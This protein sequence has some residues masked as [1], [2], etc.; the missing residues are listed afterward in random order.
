MLT[1]LDAKEANAFV[2]VVSMATD[3]TP[4]LVSSKLTFFNVNARLDYV[5]LQI[6][7]ILVRCF[8]FMLESCF[9][10]ASG[11]PHYKT[12]DGEMIH[13][14]GTCKYTLTRSTTSNDTCGFH[15]I[16]KNEHRNK[17]T[18]VSFTRRVT[19]KILGKKIGLRQKG[20]VMV[21]VN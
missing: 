4:A 15:V 13:F 9:C 3:T 21:I 16:V 17:N 8:L 1:T 11:D 14:M 12:Y 5:N 6:I 20:L 18:R 7:T 2:N 10:M 19:L